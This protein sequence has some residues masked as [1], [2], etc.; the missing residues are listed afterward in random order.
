MSSRRFWGVRGLQFRIS[1]PLH[2][3][4]SHPMLHLPNILNYI[5]YRNGTVYCWGVQ[6]LVHFPKYPQVLDSPILRGANSILHDLRSTRA[7][8]LLRCG[9]A[10]FRDSHAGFLSIQ[11]WRAIS[12]LWPPQ[13]ATYLH[14]TISQATLYTPTMTI[15]SQEEKHVGICK[16]YVETCGV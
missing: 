6:F 10:G 16:G 14:S 11:P 12:V 13:M 5:V 7:L 4:P 2:E 9:Y 15:S 1:T 8:H 3:R